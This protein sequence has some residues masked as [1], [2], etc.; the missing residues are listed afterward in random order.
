M[1]KKNIRYLALLALLVAGFVGWN[2]RDLPQRRLLNKAEAVVFADVDSAARLLEQVDSARLTVSA[3]A[4]YLLL[5]ALVHEEQWL[6]ANGDTACR[7]ELND[8]AWVARLHHDYVRFEPLRNCY[9]YADSAFLA[10]S[11]IMLAYTYYDKVTCGGVDGSRE[12]RNRFGRCCWLLSRGASPID[13]LLQP[14]RLLHLASF[15]AGQTE[16]WS[17]AYRVY[18]RFATYHRMYGAINDNKPLICTLRAF[19]AFRR[20]PDNAQN[21]RCLVSDYAFDVMANNRQPFRELA[22]LLFRMDS[23]ASHVVHATVLEESSGLLGRA[24]PSRPSSSRHSLPDSLLAPLY[25]LLQQTQ[26]RGGISDVHSIGYTQDR[27]FILLKDVY[28]LP[29]DSTRDE[30]YRDTAWERDE[31][32]MAVRRATILSPSYLRQATAWRSRMFTYLILTLVFAALAVGIALWL[33]L[34]VQRRLRQEERAAHEREAAHLAERLRQKDAM[35]AMLRGHI[36]DKSEILDMLEPTAGKR[37][38]IN[39]RNWREIEATLDTADNGFVN[40]LRNQFPSF[41]E[42]DFRLCMLTRLK[43]TNTALSAIYLISVS[44]VQHRKQK[45]K[46]EGFGVTDPSVT[47]DQLIAAY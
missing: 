11:A 22:S 13:S 33:R 3:E 31:R 46:K 34:R 37:T 36:M 2:F 26:G 16:D 47:F 18:Q 12:A 8:T 15:A 35:I 5:R 32:D 44:A 21:L 4:H 9:V 30:S 40:R 42:E 28:S 38:I 10:D 41:T 43:L 29:A 45:L 24:F 1:K 25:T 39:A 17:L 20:S 7:F 27:Q 6:R 14:E 23:L 19:D